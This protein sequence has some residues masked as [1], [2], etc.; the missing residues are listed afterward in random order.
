MRER[1]IDDLAVAAHDLGPALAVGL[2]DR[3]LDVRDRFVARQ[4]ARDREEARLHDRVDARAHAG[5]LRQVVGV[6]R[7]E[8]DLLVDDLFLHLPRQVVPDLVGGKRRVQQ[9]RRARRGMLEHV[10]LVH[11]LEL[12]A[13]DEA[14]AVHQVRRPDRLLARAQVGDRDRARFL[15]V[16]DE[17][18]LREEIRFLADDL[19]GVLVG[20]DR[21]VGAEA[22]EHRRRHVLR[23]GPERRIPRERR[24]RH[25]VDDADGEMA[26]RLV[27]GDL[28]ED[29]LHHR[30][31]ELF[32]RQAVA[33]GDDPRRDRERRDALRPAL[34]RARS[35]RRD[36]AGR[37][38]RPAPSSDRARRGCERSSAARPG[39]RS[40]RTGDTAGPSA[41]R[42]SRREPSGSPTASCT[43]SAPDPISTITRSAAGI[44][45]VLEQAVAPAGQVAR[46]PASSAR[47]SPGHAS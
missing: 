32:R 31:R 33:A 42:P 34:R 3:L 25:V 13:G 15:R 21:A 10:D 18:A 4:Q 39:T 6:D 27:L 37:R 14:G 11:E 44:A 23:L 26:L 30:R 47:R 8:A 38:A 20:A 9:E 19:D 16:V 36:R 24:V 12:V 46:T 22:V 29:R 5:A 43:V 45:D 28:V 35:S 40:A 7:E 17:V 41:R 1:L 2:L